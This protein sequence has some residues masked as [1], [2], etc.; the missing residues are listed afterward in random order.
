MARPRFTPTDEQR[1]N[2]KR[3][4]ALGI[5]QDH[6]AEMI[7][8]RSEKTLRKYFQ[9]ELTRGTAEANR[10]VAQSLYRQATSGKCPAASMFWLKCRAGWRERKEYDQAAQSPPPFIVGLVKDDR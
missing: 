5:R 8:L 2:V 7:G 6:I 1:S 10:Q 9:S 4:A 3:L